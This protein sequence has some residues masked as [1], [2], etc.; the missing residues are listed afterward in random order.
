MLLDEL[1]AAAA[2]F[3]RES[4]L[5]FV[6]ELGGMRIFE[7]PLVGVADAADP[8]FATLKAPAAVGPQHLS[9]AEWLPGARAAVVCFLPFTLTVR[10]AN[11]TPG[12]PAAEWLYG[13][14][15][16]EAFNVTLRRHLAALLSAGGHLALAPVLDE[17]FAITERRSNWSE[18]H[19]AYIA[20][21][22]TL[23][24][25]CSLITARGA[26]GRIGSLITTYPLAPTPRP[27][28]DT[29]EYCTRCGA[30]IDRCPP[31]AIDASGK[32]HPL[33]SDYVDAM[34]ERFRPRYGCGKC[35]T[36]VPCEDR[37]PGRS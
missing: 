33:C 18:R 9:P 6:P 28:G 25:N 2:L 27:Y 21:L 5:N 34:M 12:L 32:S 17:R 24:L 31:A 10:A 3:T 19:A 36:A 20:G 37:I 11:R 16:G 30:C 35:Q 15:E 26:A 29:H 22:G 1:T 8:L 23:S 4:P 14:I 13:R 7:S